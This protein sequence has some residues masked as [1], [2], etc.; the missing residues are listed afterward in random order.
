MSSSWGA[1]QE[2]KDRELVKLW[3]FS[4]S[5][6]KLRRLYDKSNYWVIFILY[7][8]KMCHKWVY[9]IFHH[10]VCIWIDLQSNWF[11]SCYCQDSLS[12]YIDDT[13]LS[14]ILTF[15]ESTSRSL[16]RFSISG[17]ERFD[18]VL[19]LYQRELEYPLYNAF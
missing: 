3:A 4:N 19:G 7:H 2:G 9:S 13:C 14:R 17:G 16:R 8:W 15:K 10:S 18:S 11:G 1:H 5:K 12:K 6:G